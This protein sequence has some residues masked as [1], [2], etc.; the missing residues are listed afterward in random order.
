V[1]PARSSRGLIAAPK[2][3]RVARRR[4]SDRH[5]AE[6]IRLNITDMI[7]FNKS[8]SEHEGSSFTVFVQH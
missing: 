1:P 8:L 5:A 2:R 7:N 3:G 4:G 6:G